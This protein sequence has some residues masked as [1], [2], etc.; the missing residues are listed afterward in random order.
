MAKEKTIEVV[1]V[2]IKA[3]PNAKF[4][5]KLNKIDKTI[6]AY[7]SGKM[8]KFY[9]KVVEGDT[10][11]LELSPYDLSQGRIVYRGEKK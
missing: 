10:V 2:V 4:L 3:L 11:T 1:G 8:R 7:M 6:L 9:I 5:V